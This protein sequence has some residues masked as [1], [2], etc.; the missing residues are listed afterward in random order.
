MDA[1]TPNWYV[2]DANGV[3][4]YTNAFGPGILEKAVATVLKEQEGGPDPAN[5]R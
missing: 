4:R 1:E 3:I 2:V 5:R